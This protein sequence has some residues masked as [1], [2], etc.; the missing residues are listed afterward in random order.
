M[1]K[2]LSFAKPYRI[3]V[4][5]ALFLLLVEVTVDLMQPLFL[6]K[7]I[8]EGIMMGDLSVVMFW[9]GILLLASII[10]FSAGIIN[11][12]YAAHVSQSIGFDIRAILYKK[13]QSFSFVQLDKFSSSSLITRITNDITQIQQFFFMVL[14][15]MLRVPLLSI[16]AVIMALL[17]NWKLTSILLLSVPLSLLCLYLVLKKGTILFRK[18]Q[19]RLDNVNRMMQENLMGIML[20][21]A[22]VRKKHESIRFKDANIELKTETE[23]ALRVME[24]STPIILVLMNVSVLVILWFSS[25]SINTGD[26][27]VGEVVAIVNY[28]TR[29]ASAFSIFSFLIM[30]FSRARASSERVVEVIETERVLEDEVE[31]NSR[32]ESEGKITFEHVTFMYPDSTTTVLDDVSFSVD[33]GQKIAIMGA[34][35]SGKSTMFQL[36]P[37]LYDVNEGK[38]LLGN[39]DI[40]TIPTVD[41]RKQIGYVPQQSLLFTGTIRDNI[42]WGKEN[43]TFEEI[44]EAAKDAQIHDTINKLPN[45]YETIVGQKGVNLSG[46][47]KQRLS[48]ARALLR[49]PK[50]LLLDDSTSALDLKTEAKLLEALQKYQCTTMII[51]QKVS[52]AIDADVVLLLEDGKIIANGTHEELIANSELYQEIYNSQVGK[53]IKRNA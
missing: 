29:I 34:T 28:I 33:P 38:I 20:I 47:Q 11:S 2:L 48:I 5:I 42:A 39:T 1:F 52:T 17:I 10:S 30:I 19:V 16:G 32:F 9:G 7:I 14:R 27:K 35:G 43:A 4:G 51:T 8:D 49:K 36:I 18:V 53:G 46:G 31:H 40:T 25:S 6:A 13:A 12:F 24:I 44:I 21:K 45:K 22:F 41:V 37:R 50:I 15:I 23:K 3:A 26:V